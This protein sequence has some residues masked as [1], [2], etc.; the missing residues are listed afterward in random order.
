[1]IPA[2]RVQGAV[3]EFLRTRPSECIYSWANRIQ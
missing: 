1:V 3:A 2:I